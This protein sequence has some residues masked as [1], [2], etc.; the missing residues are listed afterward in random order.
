MTYPTED[1]MNERLRAGVDA[2]ARRR[3][4]RH[5]CRAAFAATRGAGLELRH[6]T[7]LAHL[8]RELAD[9]PDPTPPP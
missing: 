7:K 9:L 5:R 3:S 2:A 6:A 8:D 1:E 4:E